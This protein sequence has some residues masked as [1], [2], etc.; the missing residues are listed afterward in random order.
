MLTDLLKVCAC[1][2]DREDEFVQAYRNDMAKKNSR[3][4]GA[5]KSE[6]KRIENRCAEI[7]EIIRKLYEDNVRGR[8]TDERFDIMS[9]GY[10]TEKAELKLKAEKLQVALQ[11]DA[12]DEDNLEQFK[13]LV[14]RYTEISELNTEILNAFVEK[15]YVGEVVKTEI[16]TK[17][18]RKKYL[19]TRTIRIVYKFIGAVNLN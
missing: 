11:M 18:K 16:L 1:V 13:R 4:Y 15:I 5:S 6:L 2:R 10:E 3:L 14:R 12:R 19:K 8:I 17:R 9:K 7:D